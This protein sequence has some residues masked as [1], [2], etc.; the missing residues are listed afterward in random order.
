MGVAAS[1]PEFD[2]VLLPEVHVFAQWDVRS[3]RSMVQSFRR[4]GNTG[5]GFSMVRS[6]F[7]AWLCTT[8]CQRIDEEHAERIFRVFDSDRSGAVDVLEFLGGISMF[9]RGSFVEKMRLC[10][11]LYDFNINGALS[12]LELTLFLRQTYSGALKMLGEPSHVKDRDMENLARRAFNVYDDDN[13]KAMDVEEFA[14]WAVGNRRVATLL[15]TIKNCSDRARSFADTDDSASEASDED[16]SDLEHEGNFWRVSDHEESTPNPTTGLLEAGKANEPSMWG[17]GMRRKVSSVPDASLELAWVYGYRSIGTGSR[18]NLHYIKSGKGK[19]LVAYPAASTVVV[20]NANSKTPSQALYTGHTDEV[21]ATALHP[22]REIIA[23]GQ[24]GG[25]IHVW[26]ASV[27]KPALKC[28]LPRLHKEGVCLLSFSKDGQYLASVGMDAEHTMAV[29][30]WASGTLLASSKV[31]SSVVYDIAWAPR[32]FTAGHARD[33]SMSIAVCGTKFIREYTM[34]ARGGVRDTISLAS[35]SPAMYEL[36]E[37]RLVVTSS[38]KLQTFVSLVYMKADLVVGTANGELYHFKDGR[39]HNVIKAHMERQHVSC[40]CEWSDGGVVSGS[41]DGIVRRWDLGLKEIGSGVDVGSFD[42]GSAGGHGVISVRVNEGGDSMLIGTRSAEIFEL[43]FPKGA[44][45]G[46][47]PKPKKLVSAHCASAVQSVAAHPALP[48][49]ATC[50]LDATVRLWNAA[51]HCAQDSVRLEAACLSACFSPDG[52]HLSVG[53]KSGDVIILDSANP[54]QRLATLFLSGVKEQ[55]ATSKH[56]LDVNRRKAKT[57]NGI[58]AVAYSPDGRTLAVGS[59]NGRIFMYNIRDSAYFCGSVCSGGGAAIRTIDWSTDSKCLQSTDRD[60]RLVRWDNSGNKISSAPAV[61]DL[62]W[63]TWT[64]TD[65]WPVFGAKLCSSMKSCCRSNTHGQDLL[66]VGGADGTINLFKYPC[67]AEKSAPAKRAYHGHVGNVSGVQFLPGDASVLSIS[68]GDSCILQW[69]C[70]HEELSSDERAPEIPDEEDFEADVEAEICRG[71]LNQDLIAPVPFFGSAVAPQNYAVINGTFFHP[72]HGASPLNASSDARLELAWVKGYRGNDTRNNICFA[73]PGDEFLYFTGCTAIAENATRHI[74]TQR[75]MTEHKSEILCMEKS[76]HADTVATGDALGNVFIWNMESMVVEAMLRVSGAARLVSFSP[77]ARIVAVLHGGEDEPNEYLSTFEWRHGGRKIGSTATSS[78]STLHMIWTSSSE[79]V[80][81]GKKHVTFWTNCHKSPDPHLGMF[82][83][84]PGRQDIR[85]QTALCVSQSAAKNCILTGMRDG[86]IYKWDVR[87]RKIIDSVSGAH[88]SEAV[89]AIHKA[90]GGAIY[91]GS[92]GGSIKQWGQFG[93]CVF[94]CKLPGEQKSAVRAL[95]VNGQRIIVGTGNDEIYSVMAGQASQGS[96]VRLAHSHRNGQLGGVAA[97]PEHQK[98]LT[99]GDDAFLRLW[100]I[101]TKSQIE[102]HALAKGKARAIAVSPVSTS[103][104]KGASAGDRASFSEY[105]VA[106]GYRNGS[107]DIFKLRVE[108]GAG[109]V[110]ASSS[111]LASQADAMKQTALLHSFDFPA[112]VRSSEEAAPSDAIRCVQFSPD[113][114]FLAAG[115][116]DGNIYIYDLEKKTMVSPCVSGHKR[117]VQSIDWACEKTS[118][119]SNA[120]SDATK[121]F[122]R[123]SSETELLF[124]NMLNIST[125]AGGAGAAAEQRSAKQ[126][127]ASGDVKNKSWF[128]CTCPIGWPVQGAASLANDR[129][130]VLEC[131]QRSNGHAHIIAGNSSGGITLYPYP[132][133]ERAQAMKGKAYSGH[134]GRATSVCFTCDDEFAVSVCADDNSILV[135]KADET[136]EA[137]RAFKLWSA[138]NSGASDGPAQESSLSY[139]ATSIADAP[140]RQS[141]W[142]NAKLER[143][144]VLHTPEKTRVSHKK[145]DSWYSELREPDWYRES[146]LANRSAPMKAPTCSLSLQWIH[147]YRSVGY[148]GVKYTKDGDLAFFAGSTGIIQQS[149]SMKNGGISKQVFHTGHNGKPIM[150]MALSPDGRTAATGEGGAHPKI[151]MW[152]I[153]SGTTQQIIECPFPGSAKKVGMN[154]TISG[155]GLLAFSPDGK[156]LASVSLDS[157]KTLCVHRVQSGSVIAKTQ[158][159]GDGTVV[160]L[161][162]AGVSK[163]SGGGVN[164]NLVTGGSNHIKFWTLDTQKGILSFKSGTFSQGQ[165]RTVTSAAFFDG[166]V[167]TG[168]ADGSLSKWSRSTATRSIPAHDMSGVSSLSLWGASYAGGDARGGP[169]GLLSGAEDGSVIIWDDAL[170]KIHAYDSSD[171]RSSLPNANACNT[172][173]LGGVRSVSVGPGNERIAVAFSNGDILEGW[174]VVGQHHSRKW[175]LVNSGQ[176]SDED[177]SGNNCIVAAHPSEP[178]AYAVCNHAA[179]KWNTNTHKVT[180]SIGLDERASAL[181]VSPVANQIA[182]GSADGK[183]A[184]RSWNLRALSSKQCGNAALSFMQYSPDGSHLAAGCKDAKIYILETRHYAVKTVLACS[185]DASITSIDWSSDSVYIRNTTRTNKLFHWDALAGCVCAPVVLRE[186][187]W[188]T[189]TCPIGWGLQGI[190]RFQPTAC[191]KLNPKNTTISASVRAASTCI[192]SGGPDGLLSIH[193]YPCLSERDQGKRYAGHTHPISSIAVDTGNKRVFSSS[194]TDLSIFEYSVNA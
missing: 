40:L 51:K 142:M 171:I 102:E 106:V 145:A 18:N 164:V 121:Y 165:N 172:G 184:I 124:W 151:I 81:V 138:K 26:D 174:A 109:A 93:E 1:R 37:T 34:K 64:C 159:S 58:T 52:S 181:A 193:R 147:G 160:S 191:A 125:S 91:S 153:I 156:M 114:L 79:V 77:N 183:I 57:Q 90:S 23:S 139:A 144:F 97:H 162:F 22:G 46:L 20:L 43:S 50:G 60:G 194:S 99:V 146:D 178:Y 100:D 189:Q 7:E 25:D 65:G 28:V 9:A 132:C 140:L 141:A 42:I 128:T 2:R 98:F 155:V 187:K 108:A 117:C 17:D 182:I 154:E 78:S 88:A 143:R 45:A 133:N 131:V 180:A 118:S 87:T 84:L 35:R 83:T 179:K 47:K 82:C 71:E 152:D 126:I 177:A 8:T 104:E 41:K 36:S 175:S 110:Q 188:A 120:A 14:H 119:G 54:S 12:P 170:N 38:G 85:K 101:D 167:V 136:E 49:F 122:M 80:T 62:A 95:A 61:K 163:S 75:F 192:L 68:D 168:H 30:H 32:Q 105:S 158:I 134:S 53:L 66:A 39:L 27:E 31:D 13:N 107:I 123:S 111:A 5:Y 73:G 186:T 55:N 4:M 169:C 103:E 94:E 86:S 150:C 127:P 148:D 16:L 21:S 149:P 44:A 173:A 74:P 76:P 63:S 96:F 113:G 56:D 161:I 157:N 10:F 72:A 137:S 48:V 129:S 89:T 70:A 130:T 190:Q 166:S 33:T 11:E 19:D 3:V 6:Q 24:I 116:Q 67:P 135:W 15:D 115:C 29:W 59:V 185:E 69:K 176:A 112:G 92:S